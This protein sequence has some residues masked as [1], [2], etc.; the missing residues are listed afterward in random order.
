M[1]NHGRRSKARTN[2]RGGLQ[3]KRMTR[4]LDKLAQ[5]ELFDKNIMPQL[6]KMV[7]ENWPPDKIRKAFAPIMQAQMIR[8]GLQGNLT[9]LKDTLDRHE[10][11]AVQRVENKTVYARMDKRELAAL[12]LQKLRD[13]NIISIDGKVL[14][15]KDETEED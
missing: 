9:A 6:K 1:A 15:G 13:A 5:F 4:S 2:E 12:A 7:L 3:E 8:A 10:G 14:K 11:T